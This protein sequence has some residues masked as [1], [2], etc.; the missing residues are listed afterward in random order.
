MEVHHHSH[1]ERKRWTHY[2]FE[3]FML[4]LAV[5]AGFLAE[6]W[7]EHYI[8]HARAKVL[9]G[10]LYND[11]KMD[12]SQLH[13]ILSFTN[14][15]NNHIDSLTEL[16]QHK[17]GDWNDTTFTTHIFWLVRYQAFE[18]SRSTFDQLK[19]SGSLRYFD[20][21]IVQLLNNYDVTAQEIKRREDGEYNILTTI[22]VPYAQRVVNFEMIYAFS[23][24][25]AYT[26]KA[27]VKI[28]NSD[29]ADYLS[30]QAIG[31]KL[32]R[33]RLK[34]FYEKLYQQAEEILTLL[35]KEYHLKN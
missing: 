2:L 22:T 23:F 7:R 9:A 33:T 21:E 8:E 26:H 19:S 25:T 31:L 18:R 24:N 17:P 12:T 11:L 27:Y 29:E 15:R 6:N 14:A 3:F 5:F 34:G 30:N 16:L 32:N 10:S 13:T 4:F 1:T 35:K 20:Q 28:K